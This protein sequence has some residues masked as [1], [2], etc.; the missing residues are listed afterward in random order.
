MAGFRAL[1]LFVGD[2]PQRLHPKP[3]PTC[4]DTPGEWHSQDHQDLAVARLLRY[5]R[6][7]FFVDLAAN[8]PVCLSNTRALERDY[9]WEGICIDANPDLQCHCCRGAHWPV[10]LAIARPEE[11]TTE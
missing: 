6:G 9:G 5:K 10:A 4:N 8:E 1:H 3:R 2:E 11:L 7:G